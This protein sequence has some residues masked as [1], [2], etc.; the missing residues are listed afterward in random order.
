MKCI[1]SHG[2]MKKGTASYNVN[3]KGYHLLLDKVPAWICDQCGE[4]YFEESEVQSI[5]DVIRAIDQQISK[6]PESA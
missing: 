2:T 3:R 1:Y 4:P 5:Q 6:L